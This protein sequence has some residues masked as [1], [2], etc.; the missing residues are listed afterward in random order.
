MRGAVWDGERLVVTD[1]LRLRALRAGEVRI[2]V[3]ASGICHT[4]IN[5]MDDALVIPPVVLGHEAAGVVEAFAPDVVGL[6]AGEPVLV[7]N[8]T[9]CGVCRECVRGDAANC[10]EAWG[11]APDHPFSL[12]GQPVASFANC[13]SFAEQI[14]V[15]ADQVI[16]AP[17][18]SS[19]AAALI[20]CAVS[21]GYCGARRLGR[22]APGDTVVVL[23]I[24]GI[25]VNA[26]QGAAH[27]GAARIVAADVNAGKEA[28]AHAFGA[29]GFMAVPRAATAADLADRLRERAAAPIDVAMECS[30]ATPAIEAAIRAVKQG[31]T[32]VLIGF[33]RAGA[34]ASFPVREVVRGRTIVATMNGGARPWEDYPA[35]V[36]LA[37]SGG[38]DLDAQ[39]TGVWPLEGIA[40]AIAAVR[41]GRVT[42]AVLDYTLGAGAAQSSFP[43]ATTG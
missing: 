24:G 26:L 21:T 33:G 39:I 10:D 9:P 42:R 35:L 15:R 32:C 7:S 11:F 17:G 31:G 19:R 13:S 36:E 23:G 2:R 6:T 30:G 8:Q 29:T 22:V 5:M 38:I 40:D 25:G 28:I 3:L 43:G 14:V 12:A 27:A 20:G 41:A 1:A 18:L 34:E 16:P 37:R 4:D